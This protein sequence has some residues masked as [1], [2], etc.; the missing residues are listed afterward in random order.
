MCIVKSDNITNLINR[1]IAFSYSTQWQDGAHWL[2]IDVR[3]GQKKIDSVCVVEMKLI[4]RYESASLARFSHDLVHLFTLL[5][6]QPQLESTARLALLEAAH[7]F[8]R[9][10]LQQP[11]SHTAEESKPPKSCSFKNESID[12]ICSCWSM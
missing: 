8:N 6:L 4:P 11:S 7:K 5:L 2:N 1:I 3:F 10:T 12:K 9:Y